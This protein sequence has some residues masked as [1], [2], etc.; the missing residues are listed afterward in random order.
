MPADTPPH[1]ITLLSNEV[2][3]RRPRMHWQTVPD[4]HQLA[5]NVP[6]QMAQKVMS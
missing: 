1:R 6:P 2:A 5:V 4:N 3:H